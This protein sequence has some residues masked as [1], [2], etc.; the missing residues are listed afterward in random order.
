VAT[1]IVIILITVV[2][3]AILPDSKEL[4]NRMPTFMEASI[5]VVWIIVNF[6][7]SYRLFCRQQVIGKFVNV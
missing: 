3:L 2:Q 7:L 5:T 6:W 4:I 1:T